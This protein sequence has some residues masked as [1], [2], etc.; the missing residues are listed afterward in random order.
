M[1]KINAAITAVGGYIPEDVLSNKDTKSATVFILNS[2][3]ILKKSFF[4]AIRK[5]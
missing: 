2:S 3:T 5:K 4:F 1:G